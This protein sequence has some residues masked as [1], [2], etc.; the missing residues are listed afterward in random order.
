M[1]RIEDLQPVGPT[2]EQLP[3]GKYYLMKMLRC[4][5]DFVDMDASSIRLIRLS[6]NQVAWKQRQLKEKKT[7]TSDLHVH[8]LRS[9]K[10]A[11]FPILWFRSQ[12]L[13]ERNGVQI[14]ADKLKLL[15]A[16]R[17]AK[18]RLAGRG[19]SIAKSR[20]GS[21]GIKSGLLQITP[22]LLMTEVFLKARSFCS[23]LR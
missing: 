7:G 20:S 19:R 9:Y 17:A 4:V 14:L 13:I 3:T 5:F 10:Q 22:S 16:Q 15:A 8:I 2:P 23:S 11:S 18:L 21:R 1:Q 6:R 12:T